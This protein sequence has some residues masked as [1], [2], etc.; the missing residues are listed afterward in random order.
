MIFIVNSIL[1]IVP[2]IVFAILDGV[3]YEYAGWENSGLNIAGSQ[4]FANLN[5]S[6]DN[7]NATGTTTTANAIHGFKDDA[8]LKTSEKIY[9]YWVTVFYYIESGDA[10]LYAGQFIFSK[11]FIAF[12]EKGVLKILIFFCPAYLK[13]LLCHFIGVCP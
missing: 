1:L 4:T 6:N 8:V 11:K 13:R 9:A 2:F 5:A 3:E 10:I 7:N 12:S